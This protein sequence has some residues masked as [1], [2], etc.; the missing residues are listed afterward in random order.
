V[1]ILETV[2]QLNPVV[3]YLDHFQMSLMAF[4][5]VTLAVLLQAT[6]EVCCKIT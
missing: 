3:S 2:R 1:L 6:A 5:A 4:E